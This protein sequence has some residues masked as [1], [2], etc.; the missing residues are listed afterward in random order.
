MGTECREEQRKAVSASAVDPAW[1]WQGSGS[2]GDVKAALQHVYEGC[3]PEIGK[4]RQSVRLRFEV[5]PLCGPG[6]SVRS[7]LE[8]NPTFGF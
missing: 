7:Y 5:S 3:S 2:E 6:R 4:L 8:D 1:Q